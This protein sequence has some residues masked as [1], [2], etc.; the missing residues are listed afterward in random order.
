MIDFGF[1]TKFL[2]LLPV[3]AVTTIEC[4]NPRCQEPHGYGL[5]IGWLFWTL[6]VGFPNE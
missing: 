4:A 6:Y 5:V 3:C 2:N 1:D